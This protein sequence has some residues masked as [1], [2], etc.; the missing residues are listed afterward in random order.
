[1]SSASPAFPASSVETE[2]PP[3]ADVRYD[4]ADLGPWREFVVV[5]HN[6]E[7][8]S[9]VEV[10]VQLMK[11]LVCSQPVAYG[12]MRRVEAAGKAVVATAPRERAL[13]I[14]S[15]LQQIRLTVEVRQIN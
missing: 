15:V 5:L 4:L 8:H 12:L 3:A 14:G 6:D 9:Q 7:E 13:R 10:V 11:A 2:A 1:M